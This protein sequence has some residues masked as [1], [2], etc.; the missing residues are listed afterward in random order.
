MVEKITSQDQL[1][2][3]EDL[4]WAEASRFS[5]HDFCEQGGFSCDALQDFFD[6]AEAGFKERS[7]KMSKKKGYGND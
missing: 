5:I 1:V 3:M 2:L 7:E 6:L 4:I